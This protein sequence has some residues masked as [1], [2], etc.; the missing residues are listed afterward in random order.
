M[1][2]RDVDEVAPGAV[3]V[4]NLHEPYNSRASRCLYGEDFVGGTLATVEGQGA[5]SVVINRGLFG[6]NAL[7]NEKS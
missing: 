7:I 5:A 2:L 4:A 6:A 3:N 1:A